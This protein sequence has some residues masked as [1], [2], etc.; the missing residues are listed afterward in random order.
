MALSYDAKT[1]VIGGPFSDSNDGAAWVFTQDLGGNWIFPGIKQQHPEL[2][3]VIDGLVADHRKINPMLE[4]GD[5]AFARL[6]ETVGAA[7]EIVSA[8]SALLDA[9]LATEEK[10]I[11]PFLRDAKAFP[12]PANEAELEMF[13]Q[14]FA[15]SSHGIC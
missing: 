8:L 4:A 13:A 12:P 14:G 9:H 15:W 7:A 2:A 10:H 11:V 3:A 5:R 1:A 6:P